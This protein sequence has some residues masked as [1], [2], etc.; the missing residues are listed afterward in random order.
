MIPAEPARTVQWI[1]ISDPVQSL[2]LPP[3]SSSSGSLS[4]AV[5]SSM[6]THTLQDSNTPHIPFNQLYKV[7]GRAPTMPDVEI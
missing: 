3:P 4:H 1:E 2:H 7:K 6:L 5:P